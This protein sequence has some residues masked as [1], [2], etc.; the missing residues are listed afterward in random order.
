L[1]SSRQRT[2]YIQLSCV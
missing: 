1:T 2:L